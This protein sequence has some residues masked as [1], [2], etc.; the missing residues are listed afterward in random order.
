V[1]DEIRHAVEEYDRAFAVLQRSAA[2]G[3]PGKAGNGQEARLGQAYHRL[4]QLGLKPQLK[5]KY[6]G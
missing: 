5:G 3:C 2:S 1:T 6:R 4:V